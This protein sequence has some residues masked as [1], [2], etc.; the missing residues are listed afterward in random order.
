M[1]SNCYE[2]A[3]LNDW[4]DS[5]VWLKDVNKIPRRFWNNKE[6]IKLLIKK[7]DLHYKHQLFNCE[8]GAYQKA[9]ENNWLD[10]FF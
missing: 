5:Y 8:R 10:E 4:I 1:F 2:V 7:K 9:N 6:H 3:W